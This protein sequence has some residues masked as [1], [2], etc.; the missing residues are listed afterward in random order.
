MRAAAAIFKEKNVECNTERV[1][2]KVRTFLYANFFQ[3]SSNYIVTDD[4]LVCSGGI[5]KWLFLSVNGPSALFIGPELKEG[6]FKIKCALEFKVYFLWP[7]KAKYR[8]LLQKLVQ[9]QSLQKLF[10]PFK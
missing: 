10:L 8:H 9:F 5:Q 2:K 7:N 4:G 3:L 6:H 1:S